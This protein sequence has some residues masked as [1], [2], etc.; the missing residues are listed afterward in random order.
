MVSSLTAMLLD[1]QDRVKRKAFLHTLTRG[2]NKRVGIFLEDTDVRLGLTFRDNQVEL[3]D[4]NGSE[5]VDITLRGKE[6]DMLL[7]FRGE[8]LAYLHAR[9]SIQTK[10]SVRDQLKLDAL[11]RLAGEQ[12]M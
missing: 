9:Q 7:L 12:A 8:V 6:S 10:A 4:W 5:T 11:L 3:Y 2:W 1:F